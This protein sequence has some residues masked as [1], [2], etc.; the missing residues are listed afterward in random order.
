MMRAAIALVL[1][2]AAGAAHAHPLAPALLELKER[3]GGMVDVVWK[4]SSLKVPG[5]NVQPVLPEGCPLVSDMNVTEAVDSVTSHWTI[6]CGEQ[7]LVGRTIAVTDLLPAR[8]DVLLRLALADGRSM[9][10]V[11][12]SSEPSIVIPERARPLDVAVD[13]ARLGIDNI[14]GG[15]DHLLFVFG[16]VL[17]VRSLGMLV[18]TVTAFTIGHSLTL[19]LAVL[20]FVTYPSRLIELLIALSV[21]LLAVELARKET[22]QPT[23][24]RRLPWVIAGC[25][26]LLHGLGFA[27]AL[28]EVGLPSGEIPL[29]LFTFNVGIEIGQI[30]FVVVVFATRAVVGSSGDSMPRWARQV[31]LYAMGSLAAFWCFE[32]A[33]A[34]F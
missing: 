7:G 4:T 30:V 16:L 31:S 21:F 20:G 13:Y 18:R 17:L 28:T 9:N 24:M 5:T 3:P 25:F 11:I 29:A 14:L 10:F 23:L 1:V 27:G 15:P 33:S 34:L 6:D 8:I 26:G 32:R 12:R 19:S 22:A 2:L